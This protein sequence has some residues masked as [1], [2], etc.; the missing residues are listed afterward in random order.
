VKERKVKMAHPKYKKIGDPL[1]K[2]VE[3]CAEVIHVC[4]KID[5]FGFFGHHPDD[6][7]KTPNAELLLMEIE[8]AKEAFKNIQ[9]HILQL[10]KK[11][12]QKK[13]TPKW[14]QLWMKGK[15]NRKEKDD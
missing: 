5:R 10:T 4:C 11:E 9:E 3:E 1:T 13:P 7:N 15:L 8:D 12:W 6:E 14:W 2:V